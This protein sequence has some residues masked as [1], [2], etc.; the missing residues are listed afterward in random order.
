MA[1]L[2]T[3]VPEAKQEEEKRKQMSASMTSLPDFRD[4]SLA[5]PKREGSLEQMQETPID[6]GDTAGAYFS[7][8]MYYVQV[9]LVLRILP[10]LNNISLFTAKSPNIWTFMTSSLPQLI[11][12]ALLW[13]SKYTP[14][15]MFTTF[16]SSGL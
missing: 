11:F 7:I 12:S 1:F 14:L 16:K 8:F 2:V 13:P 3:I 6:E 9:Y 10:S 5:E 4:G 15:P